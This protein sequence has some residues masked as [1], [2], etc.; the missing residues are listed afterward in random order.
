MSGLLTSKE[1]RAKRAELHDVNTKLLEKAKTE[2]RAQ[3]SVEETA[4]WDKRD[5]DIVD[6][7]AQIKRVEDHETREAE[8]AASTGVRAGRPDARPQGGDGEPTDETR[9]LA[10]AAW[11]AQTN[12]RSRRLMTQEM[13]DAAQ[14]LGV[15]LDE[16]ELTF[17][18]RRRAP[19]T[20]DEAMLRGM[21]AD[22]KRALSVGTTTAGGFTVPEGFSGQLEASMLAF[23]GMRQ[24]ATVFRTAQGNDLPWPTYNDTGN[25]GELL[26]ENTQANEQDVT[27]GQIIF[28]AY[29]YS[30]KMV[31]ISVEL[32]QDSAFDLASE[33]GKILGERLGRI[34]NTHFTTG[35]NASKPQG[36]VTASSLGKTGAGGQVAT[37]IYDD[38]VDLE[39]SVDP[40]YRRL[41]GTGFMMADAMLKV[42]KKLKDSQNRPLWLPGLAV[43]EPDTILSYPYTINQ[44]IAA[45][46]ANAKSLLFGNIPKYRIRDVA[47][48]VLL[49]LNERF[50]E[51]HQ[52]AFL[53]FLRADGRML[54]AGTDPVKHYV[55]PA[56]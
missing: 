52:V 50:A 55:H 3:L 35:D 9:A 14:R 29:K 32:L 18:L 47:E 12:A 20:H 31:K 4:E 5:K 19:R 26:A 11:I 49:R 22:E 43:R 48:I 16:N 13:R 42:I 21:T 24:A 2:N 53:A 15:V 28:K 54:D 45:P 36:I 33:L 7:T 38:L 40:A 37:I 8:L 23:G 34:T 25:T 44:D 10:L 17:N 46:A 27:F 41:P 30:S 56:A 39:H 51:F 6:L 1:L